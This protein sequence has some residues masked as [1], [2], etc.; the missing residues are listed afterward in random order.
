MTG[1]VQPTQ[2]IFGFLFGSGTAYLAWRAKSLTCSGAAAAAI[3][4]GLIFGLGGVPWAALLLTFFITSSALSRAFGGRK[5]EM[6]EKFSK[7]AVRDWQQAAAN[8]GLG[9][10]LVL[11][12]ALLPGEAWPWVAYCGAMAAVNADTWATEIGVLSSQPPRS[13]VSF[14]RV[15]AGTSGG[16]SGLGTMATIGGAGTIGAAAW[17]LQ[18]ME[19]GWLFAAII[20]AAGTGGSLIDSLL[21]ATVQA[22]YYCPTDEK[23]TEQHPT[24]R[25]GTTTERIRGWSWLNNDLV[26]F[27]CSASG[28]LLAL[29]LWAY[30]R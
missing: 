22:I 3:S 18:G 29:M 9:A 10:L 19:A 16:L 28:A 7:G 30:F 21:G 8:G 6:G 15:E 12:Q 27:I 13:I 14:K 25:C 23:E 2:L 24:H 17:A 26:N 1:E 11:A 20:C 5:A 4:G